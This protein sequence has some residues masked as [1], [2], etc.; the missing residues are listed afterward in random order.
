MKKRKERK[1]EKKLLK[2]IRTVRN[3]LQDDWIH[4]NCATE[5]CMGCMSCNAIELDRKLLALKGAI[6]E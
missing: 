6:T 2:A 3:H 4:Y 1:A 5:S